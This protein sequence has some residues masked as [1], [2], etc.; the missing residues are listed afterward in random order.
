MMNEEIQER[1]NN[2][3]DYA[4]EDGG[5]GS[6][7]AGDGQYTDIRECLALTTDNIMIEYR[8]DE[9]PIE[10]TIRGYLCDPDSDMD[11]MWMAELIKCEWHGPRKVY[12]A[13]YAIQ[14]V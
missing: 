14:Q 11:L 8:D 13:D 12:I 2:K 9:E 5:I 6:Y 7:E 1:I 4:V 10:T 3:L